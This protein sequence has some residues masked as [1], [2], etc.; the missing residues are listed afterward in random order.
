MEDNILD[1]DQLLPYLFVLAVLSTLAFFLARYLNFTKIPQVIRH[2]HIRLIELILGTLIF[3]LFPVIVYPFFIKGMYYLYTGIELDARTKIPFHIH[4]YVVLGVP[5]S[6]LFGLMFFFLSW[7]RGLL[8]RV[9]GKSG[10]KSIGYHWCYGVLAYL[11]CLPFVQAVSGSLNLL[12]SFFSEEALKDEQTAVSLLKQFM[13]KGDLN[14]VIFIFLVYAVAVP[15]A[16]EILFRGLIFNYMRR[17]L[18]CSKSL[19]L[20]AA[21]FASLHYSADQGW[22]NLSLLASLF[23]VGYFLG[24]LRERQGS[25]WAP[26]GLH[27]TQNAV[28]TFIIYWGVRSSMAV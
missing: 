9:W 25:L 26:I 10:E 24:Y 11:I 2:N 23:I 17:Y 7:E 18:S 16:E 1:T 22:M 13:Y 6:S 28:S 15:I 14:I 5:L 12:I 20:S 3:F 21:L 8:R 19:I 4:R 27:M